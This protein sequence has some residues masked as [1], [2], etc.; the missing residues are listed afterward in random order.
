[1]STLHK[2]LSNYTHCPVCDALLFQ[3]LLITFDAF[4]KKTAAQFDL[5]IP[6]VRDIESPACFNFIKYRDD[7][8]KK[9]DQYFDR[10]SN[11]VLVSKNGSFIFGS[12]VFSPKSYSVYG[13]CL[14]SNHYTIET[15]ETIIN[16]KIRIMNE[17]IWIENY[18]VIND[19]FCGQTKISTVDGSQKLA[20]KISPFYDLKKNSVSDIVSKIESLLIL[21]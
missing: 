13:Y 5:S 6:Y 10:S 7:D 12:N 2:F 8:D 14:E 4:T 17:E 16:S 11:N 21:S 9:Y 3:Q 18:I 1:M 20:V 15:E 19:F